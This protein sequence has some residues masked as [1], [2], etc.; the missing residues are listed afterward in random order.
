MEAVSEEEK[1]G[2][3]NPAEQCSKEVNEALKK[4]N[5]ELICQQ[6]YVY[7]QPVFVPII[8]MIQQK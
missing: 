5:C 6:Q 7:G 1:P 2:Q 3:L 8:A 4:Y